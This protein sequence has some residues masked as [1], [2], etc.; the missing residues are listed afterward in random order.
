VEGLVVT[1]DDSPERISSLNDWD[2]FK[3]VFKSPWF[4]WGDEIIHSFTDWHTRG[5]NHE[6]YGWVR[7]H[8]NWVERK[9]LAELNEH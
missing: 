3:E 9:L 7:A 2:K 1:T 6:G 5:K 8:C 4:M